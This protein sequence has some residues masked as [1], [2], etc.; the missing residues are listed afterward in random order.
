MGQ[1]EHRTSWV[2]IYW[3]S[4]E[5]ALTSQN[6]RLNTKQSKDQKYS[7]FVTFPILFDASC[8]QFFTLGTLSDLCQTG[9]PDGLLFPTKLGRSSS[10]VQRD[11][12]ENSTGQHS[13]PRSTLETGHAFLQRKTFVSSYGHV[14]E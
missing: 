10:A 4:G 3:K 14:A 1:S 9:L 13:R 11:Q 2:Y 6:H 12:S 7:Y 5:D 8:G